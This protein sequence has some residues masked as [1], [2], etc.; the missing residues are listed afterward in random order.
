MEDFLQVVSDVVHMPQ[1]GGNWQMISIFFL[2]G[3]SR[4]YWFTNQLTDSVHS[5]IVTWSHSHIQ[6]PISS[7]VNIEQAV[8]ANK[9]LSTGGLKHARLV[10]N[11]LDE[12]GFG[13]IEQDGSQ[14]FFDIKEDIT[15]EKTTDLG[16][17][18]EVG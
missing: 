10:A 18:Y 9:I 1:F 2:H 17:V 15:E 3:D 5:H 14:I 6:N 13:R 4:H 11:A 16:I 12:R 7:T 8:A